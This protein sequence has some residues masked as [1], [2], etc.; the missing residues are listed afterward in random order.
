[1]IK[2]FYKDLFKRQADF[3]VKYRFLTE[4][5]GGRK[6]LPFQHIRNDF[7]YEHPDNDPN[8]IF[9]I[10]PEFENELGQIIQ[11]GPVL[12]EG[13]AKMWIVVPEMINYHATRIKVGQKGSFHEGARKTAECEIIEIVGLKKK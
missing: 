6:T 2:N 8:K 11:E 5:E 10:H 7:W 12:P 4:E 13:I 1:M 3:I 9:M